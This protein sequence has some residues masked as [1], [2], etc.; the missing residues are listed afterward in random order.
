MFNDDTI[1]RLLREGNDVNDIA[2]AMVDHDRAEQEADPVL[3]PDGADTEWSDDEI[4]MAVEEAVAH[5]EAVAA[6]LRALYTV[7]M[8]AAEIR[9]VFTVLADAAMDDTTNDEVVAA[10]DRFQWAVQFL[11][12]PDTFKDEL[13]SMTVR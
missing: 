11:D 8:T 9:A 7:T 10:A 6:D 5:V 1:R 2:R 3:C 4:E 12:D 13:A